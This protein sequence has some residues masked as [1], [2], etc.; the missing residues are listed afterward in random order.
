[1]A[2]TS[3]SLGVTN[4]N[5]V[6]EAM[7]RI[8]ENIVIKNVEIKRQSARNNA[9]CSVEN[10]YTAVYGLGGLSWSNP[11]ECKYIVVIKNGFFK[12]QPHKCDMSNVVKRGERGGGGISV[13]AQFPKEVCLRL[14]LLTSDMGEEIIN[15]EKK[16]KKKEKKKERKKEKEKLKERGRE[17]ERDG[18]RWRERKLFSFHH[19]YA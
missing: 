17:M 8:A 3:K 14:M 7:E 12:L 6:R 18:E 4:V 2:I 10:N 5:E 11:L 13:Y 1:M 16:K 9:F 19:F 15:I